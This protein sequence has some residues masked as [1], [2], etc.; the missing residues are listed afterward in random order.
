[1]LRLCRFRKCYYMTEAEKTRFNKLISMRIEPSQAEIK[2]QS[3]AVKEYL[4]E[5]YYVDFNWALKFCNKT[6]RLS[7]IIHNLRHIDGMKIVEWQPTLRWGSVYALYEFAPEE[8]RKDWD[9]LA[10]MP[11]W[12]VRVLDFAEARRLAG[13]KERERLN[14][15]EGQLC[16]DDYMEAINKGD[17]FWHKSI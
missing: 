14:S 5:G 16:I 3:D 11:V 7:A 9:F 17:E 4:E 8:I 1:M 6:Q 15:C 13:T 2:A 12:K 10:E